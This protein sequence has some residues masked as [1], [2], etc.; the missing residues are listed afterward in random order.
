MGDFGTD[1]VRGLLALIFVL[2][3]IGVATAVARRFG[4]GHARAGRA[5]T[6]RRLAVTEAMSLDSRRRLVLLRRDDKEYLVLLS[7]GQ[8]PDLLLDAGIGPG[9]A[10]FATAVRDS[11]F[12]EGATVAE[13]QGGQ[14]T[15]SSP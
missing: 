12:R 3:L 10:S 5:A 11:A 1:L 7:P 9:S 13:A 6:G 15:P 14:R 2:A 8:G 4:F